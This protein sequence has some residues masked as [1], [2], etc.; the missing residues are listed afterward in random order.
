MESKSDI[1]AQDIANKIKHELYHSGDYIPSEK[2][3]T[4]LYGTSRET[5]RRALDQLTELGLI[6]KIK[7]KG[8]LVLDLDRYTFPISGITSFAELNHG[9][10]MNAQT[11]VIILEKCSHLPE[12]FLPYFKEE[13]DSCGT[14]IER[15]R[16][17]QDEPDVL[18][19][20]Y[21]L[22]PPITDIPK[23][24]AEKSIYQ[25]LEQELGLSISYATKEITVTKVDNDIQKLLN[26]DNEMAVLVASR[27]YIEDTTKFELTLSYH[28][29]DRFK[30]VDFARRKHIKL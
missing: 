2:Q 27:N 5:V 21:L 22:D 17:I 7:G 28:R 16:I 6:Q 9:L 3:L 20:D 23:S 1:I 25:Y 18:D 15:L 30:F 11:K 24:V 13:A 26:L 19:C 12:K 29:P 14:H 8:S 4:T 10:N